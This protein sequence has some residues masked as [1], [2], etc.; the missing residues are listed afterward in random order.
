LGVSSKTSNLSVINGTALSIFGMEID[1]A[2]FES[3]DMDPP[4]NLSFNPRLYNKS[5]QAFTQ[6]ALNIN[7][8]LEPVEFPSRSDGFSYF[9]WYFQTLHIYCPVLHRPTTFKLVR[10]WYPKSP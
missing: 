10:T 7:V 3:A 8:R 1:I 5:F 4:D 6:T 9:E 2:D